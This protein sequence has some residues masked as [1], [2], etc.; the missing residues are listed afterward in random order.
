MIYVH[1]PDLFV[2]GNIKFQNSESNFNIIL[3]IYV[4][5]C[6][7]ENIFYK[8]MCSFSTYALLIYKPT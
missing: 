1:T 8:F 4:I 2:L 3:F 6:Y 7:R 5:Y